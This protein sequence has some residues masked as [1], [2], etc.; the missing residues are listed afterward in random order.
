MPRQAV[1]DSR[2]QLEKNQRSVVIVSSAVRLL[3][4]IE[5]F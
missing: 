2:E 4:R 3:Q 1:K 5:L